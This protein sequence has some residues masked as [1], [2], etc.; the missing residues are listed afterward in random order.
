MNLAP[1]G[2]GVV[3]QSS[4]IEGFIYPTIGQVTAE[5]GSV[6]KRNNNGIK[7]VI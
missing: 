6:I 3:A 7:V 1:V 5:K 4:P 2:E